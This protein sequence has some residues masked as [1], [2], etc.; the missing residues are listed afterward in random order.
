[1]NFT[2]AFPDWSTFIAQVIFVRFYHFVHLFCSASL[3]SDLRIALV[4]AFLVAVFQNVFGLALALLLERDTRLNRFARAAFFVPVVM[5]ALAVGYIFRAVL[6]PDGVLN[7]ILVQVL[8]ID[9]TT[10]WLGS[11]T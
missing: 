4:D 9:V 3:L 7:D 6:K 1:F 2:Y 10:A 11:T 8:S 5:S